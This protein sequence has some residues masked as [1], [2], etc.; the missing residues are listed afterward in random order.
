MKL[1]VFASILL[2]TQAATFSEIATL[3]TG[4]NAVAKID[5]PYD[6]CIHIVEHLLIDVSQIGILIA[7]KRFLEIPPV[8]IKASREIYEAI[9]CFK[10]KSETV[11]EFFARLAAPQ[12][13][14]CV[15][16]HVQAA[17]VAIKLAIQD[18]QMKLYKEAMEQIKIAVI[19]IGLAQICPK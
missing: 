3:D 7:T 13:D 16:K 18:L 19:E 8:A 10:K 1:I 12:P 4:A 5:G 14:D 15:M 17:V 11:E 9:V 2:A 6:E